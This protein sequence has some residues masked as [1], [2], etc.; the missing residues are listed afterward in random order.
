[1][2]L[3]SRLL[4]ARD[5]DT[6]Q[7]VNVQLTVN[8][9]EHDTETGKVTSKTVNVNTPDIINGTIKRIEVNTEEYHHVSIA[10]DDDEDDADFTMQLDKEHSNFFN[11][12]NNNV[13]S[14][15]KS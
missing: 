15:L 4:Q 6:R 3:E 13:D 9:D 8:L 5:V 1:M 2:A 14:K 10:L 7:F 12:Q 11:T